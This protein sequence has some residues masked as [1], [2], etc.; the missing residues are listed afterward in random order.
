MSYDFCRTHKSL[1]VTPAMAAGV[2]E[3]LLEIEDI[4]RLLEARKT[5]ILLKPEIG[6]KLQ[7]A[8]SLRRDIS[9]SSLYMVDLEVAAQWT[10]FLA[11]FHIS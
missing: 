4:V 10:T 2:N 8:L 9:L 7:E 3:R 11:T 5:T 6:K 1:R